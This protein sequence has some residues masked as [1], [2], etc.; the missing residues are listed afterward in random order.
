M[1]APGFTI[2]ITQDIY[3]AAVAFSF[4]E[5]LQQAD[6]PQVAPWPE[7]AHGKIEE[8]LDILQ[9]RYVIAQAAVEE[10]E[11]RTSADG[12]LLEQELRAVVGHDGSFAAEAELLELVERHFIRTAG[13][14]DVRDAMH[15]RYVRETN[16]KVPERPAPM[17]STVN[18][19]SGS[20]LWTA[21]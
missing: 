20:G 4:K 5:R 9:E 8:I 10:D 15:T 7:G 21:S 12:V 14:I 2:Y 16:G 13:D 1:I 6:V 3:R 17:L 19:R 18:S 11:V